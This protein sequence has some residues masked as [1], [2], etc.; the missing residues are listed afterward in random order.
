VVR[1]EYERETLERFSKGQ[2]VDWLDH[3]IE[4][5]V[6]ADQLRDIIRA[7]DGPSTLSL[8]NAH[9]RGDFILDGFG[10]GSRQIGLQIVGCR[11]EGAFRARGAHWSRLIIAGCSLEAVDIPRSKILADL[12]IERVICRTWIE[13]RG[14]SVGGVISLSGSSFTQ[15]DRD[16][17]VELAETEVGLSFNAIQLS[18]VGKISAP[19]LRVKGHARFDGANIARMNEGV[20]L[21]LARSVIDGELRLCFGGDGR[22][23]RAVGSV[24]VAAS[25]VGALVMRGAKLDGLGSP[26]LI[27]DELQVTQSVDLGGTQ[28]DGHEPFSA[29]GIMRFIRLGLRGQFQIF[30]AVLTSTEP[31]CLVLDSC[32]IGGDLLIGHEHSKLQVQ[33]QI[34]ICSGRIGGR[35]IVRGANL[36]AIGAAL[37]LRQCDVSGELGLYDVDA[38]GSLLL[39]NN[40]LGTLGIQNLALVR[41]APVPSG[42]SGN[43]CSR[44][45]TR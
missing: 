1:S 32:D 17:A 15:G 4:G 3:S 34:S 8:Q 7:G 24:L 28:A 18:T 29:N 19:Q 33:G 37:M 30:D 11:F 39:D 41:T 25:N 35:T 10:D 36:N 2:P 22:P 42:R 43:M 14:C 27:A 23:F 6:L 16:A 38:K 31:R 21:D 13:A 12:L 26:S 5:H 9:I 45:I 40:R 20:V 44:F